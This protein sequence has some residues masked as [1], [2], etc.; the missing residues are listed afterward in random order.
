MSDNDDNDNWRDVNTLWFQG[1]GKQ[2]TSEEL[3]MEEAAEPSVSE[4]YVEW[5]EQEDARE[6]A[7]PTSTFKIHSLSWKH[8]DSARTGANTAREGDTVRLLC[9]VDGC[10][11]GTNVTFDLSWKNESG[12]SSQFTSA[13]TTLK[14]G[15]AGVDVALDFSKIKESD[16]TIF[17]TPSAQGRYGAD[18]KIP[19][20]SVSAG[21]MI[22]YAPG[23]G[24]DKKGEYFEV[25]E[26]DLDALITHVED[27]NALAGEIADVRALFEQGKN[28][29]ETFK[30]AENVKAKIEKQL[31]GFSSNPSNSIQEL[32]VVTE[33]TKWGKLKKRVYIDPYTTKRG[34]VKGH[35][36][37]TTDTTIRDKVRK[38]Y[39]N[40]PDNAK[41]ELQ[42]KLK[43]VLWK[44]DQIDTQ[45]PFDWR[46]SGE[47]DADTKAGYF[48]ASGEVQ[49]FRFVAGV[50]ADTEFDLKEM[51]LTL[52]AHGDLSYSIAE[53]T[54]SGQ[55]SLPD[56][57]GVDLFNFLKPDENGNR[58]LKSGRQCRMRLT[59]S[60]TGKG[61]VGAGV[62]AAIALPAI[63]L[64]ANDKDASWSEQNK[65][66]NQR[67]AHVEGT[68]EA[69]AGARVEGQIAAQAEWRSE[70][71]P[72]FASLAGIQT[73]LA[74]SAGIG[75]GLKFKFG[76]INGKIR[77]ECGATLVVG[78]G[79]KAGYAFDIGIDEGF[80]L[81]A[82]ILNSVDYH[83]VHEF[84]DG[85][86]EAIRDYSFATFKATGKIIGSTAVRAIDEVR[87]FTS[88][89]GDAID[90]Q[91]AV[92]IS[93]TKA[94]IRSNINDMNKLR[95]A[96]PETL[97]GQVLRTIMA[98]TEPDDFAA[99]IKVL[100]SAKSA[101]EL[102][103]IIRRIV[104][105]NSKDPNGDV[106]Q[107]GIRKLQ[108]F[109]SNLD[110]YMDYANKLT[111]ILDENN[112]IIR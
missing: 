80:D 58:P 48:K 81:F 46:F 97:G 44:S 18:C 63:D 78:L 105:S 61:F 30:K 74:G 67:I 98:T 45:W 41:P 36:R 29:D 3:F 4:E 56:K 7:A 50:Q 54:V 104:A 20:E 17:F 42:K 49:F 92:I 39:K 86:F 52:T 107:E 32:L 69:F 108:N 90:E 83:Y 25:A 64:S 94:I 9:S 26:N 85:A 66:A 23:R 99:I 93:K 11:D 62:T 106:L 10:A 95:N 31:S 72:K 37:K 71:G 47:K 43:A 102:K 96:P 55:W 110:Q 14:N 82:H 33:N 1:S 57:D 21:G 12:N 5:E 40:T 28:D 101:H 77:F 16:Y 60:A 19:L 2:K 51:K 111:R 15:V 24:E 88:L 34:D 27:M 6:S 73:V 35:W 59:F 91:K 8:T 84:V 109:G 65:K 38:W 87:D 22:F 68:G 75:A 100:E 13:N 112:I 103:W 76:Y 53:G 70:T 79:G 89:L